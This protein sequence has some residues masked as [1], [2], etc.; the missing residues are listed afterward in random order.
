MTASPAGLEWPFTNRLPFKAA[1]PKPA[2]RD[3][4][5]GLV[6]TV[7]DGGC[8]LWYAFIDRRK[9]EKSTASSA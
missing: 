5:D 3:H 6:E 9:R 1:L 4:I 2:V 7:S 8:E